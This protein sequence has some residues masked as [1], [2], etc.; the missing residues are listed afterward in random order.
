M[1]KESIGRLGRSWR[2]IVQKQAEEKIPK[3]QQ[4][5]FSRAETWVK[6][7]QAVKE[8]PVET[9]QNDVNTVLRVSCSQIHQV[10]AVWE[11]KG[12]KAAYLLSAGIILPKSG[13]HN[14]FKWQIPN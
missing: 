1:S 4:E 6:K 2:N 11:P 12:K 5:L 10:W 14:A 9:R 7:D 3:P 8:V 13:L